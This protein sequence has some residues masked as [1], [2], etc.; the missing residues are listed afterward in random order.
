MRY[1]EVKCSHCDTAA[2]VPLTAVLCLPNG[3]AG[4]SPRSFAFFCPRCANLAV[5]PL[6]DDE[7]ECT[8]P[9]FD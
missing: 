8:T 9:V 3:M 5:N 6:A 4:S 7:P 1:L 2:S